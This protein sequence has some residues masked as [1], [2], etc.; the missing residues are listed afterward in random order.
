MRT[1][2]PQ[3]ASHL[4]SG[5]TMLCQCWKL[6]RRDGQVFGFTDHDRDLSFAGTTFS[7][8]TGL[9]GSEAESQLGL[10]VGGGEISGV[11]KAAAVT[12]GDILAGRLD[13]ASIETWLVNW[14]D[15][16]QRTLL[17]IGTVGEIHRSDESFT[18]EMRSPAAAWDEERGRV[19]T[20]SCSAELGDAACGIALASSTYGVTAT[21]VAVAGGQ[22]LF[23]PTLAFTDGWFSHGKASI[24]TGAASGIA[25]RIA[26]HTRQN[27]QDIIMLDRMIE[28]PLAAGDQVNL[29]AGCDKS[30][31]TCSTKFANRLN[32]RGFPH[33][34]SAD[35]V[36]SYAERGAG[37]NDGKSL[38]K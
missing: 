3:L 36:F 31:T 21:I 23:F 29:S 9:E 34:P 13:G 6:I 37:K 32:F 20:R 5:A 10:A 24:L 19:Y 14:Q 2:S 7:A 28:V 25:A 33:L 15:T 8:A 4:A 1:L 30:F 22:R 18:L 38:F 27:G 11:L 17:D 26:S 35:R 12:E 16:S